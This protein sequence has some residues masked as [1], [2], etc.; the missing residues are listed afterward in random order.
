VLIE[1]MCT[2]PDAYLMPNEF[3]RCQ[4]A[5]DAL[6]GPP[7][8]VTALEKA[9]IDT[10]R[11]TLFVANTELARGLTTIG[12]MGALVLGAG[13][14]GHQLIRATVHK[15][16]ERRLLAQLPQYSTMHVNKN[17][18]EVSVPVQDCAEDAWRTDTWNGDKSESDVEEDARSCATFMTA[19]DTEWHEVLCRQGEC[20]TGTEAAVPVP[21]PLPFLLSCPATG[22]AYIS[23]AHHRYVAQCRQSGSAFAAILYK[24]CRRRGCA[25]GVPDW[26]EGAAHGASGRHPAV[27]G[28]KGAQGR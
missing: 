12:L 24:R 10:V 9:S 3:A 7:R 11:D 13:V 23:R 6:A 26:P 2:R 15:L 27:P 1:E 25:V 18:A 8:W 19:A 21:V 22:L 17:H 5:Q 16:A 14:A 28:H 4:S 20:M